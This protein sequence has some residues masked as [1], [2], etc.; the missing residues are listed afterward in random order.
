MKKKIAGIGIA[1]IAVAGFLAFNVFWPSASNKIGDG[2]VITESRLEKAINISQLSTSEFVY[3][4]IAEKYKDNDSEKVECHIAY[5][6]IV[7]VGVD[8][9][10]ISFEIDENAKTVTPVLPPIDINSATLDEE[11]LSYIPQDPD[12][13]LKEIITICKNDAIEE[14]NKNPKLQQAA[15][16]NLRSVIEAL[17]LPILD[18]SE[19]SLKWD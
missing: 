5:H 10:D 2:N 16:D 9:S 14:A 13:A 15:E 1:V 4:G 3:N 8:M 19:Y 18:S 6:A 12:V 11:A 7:K 17:L